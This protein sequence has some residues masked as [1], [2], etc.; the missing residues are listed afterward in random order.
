MYVICPDCYH[1]NFEFITMNPNKV[2]FKCSN[3]NNQFIMD[4]QITNIQKTEN[5]IPK[6]YQVLTPHKI[7]DIKDYIYLIIKDIIEV[8]NETYY[9]EYDEQEITITSIYYNDIKLCSTEF[10]ENSAVLLALP[11]LYE[12]A[13][14][15]Y[16]W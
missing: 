13:S 3:C 10:G 5:V 16:L 14:Q 12:I 11:K 8:K 7:Q 4:Y 9:D 1:I 2:R 6:A 15:E